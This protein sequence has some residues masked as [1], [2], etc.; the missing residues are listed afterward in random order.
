MKLDSNKLGTKIHWV[1][2]DCGHTALKLP[3]NKGKRAF[4]VSTF[5][6]NTCDVCGDKKMVTETRDY[7]YPIFEINTVEKCRNC[8]KPNKIVIFGY[9]EKCAEK[10]KGPQ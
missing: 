1:C 3:E 8:R 2:S 4:E 9:C 7:G 10:M 5:H 6:M